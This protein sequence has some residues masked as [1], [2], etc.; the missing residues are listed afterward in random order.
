MQER[1]VID[2]VYEE[3]ASSTVLSITTRQEPTEVTKDCR[4]WSEM[5]YT[6]V[7][8]DDDDTLVIKDDSENHNHRL[9]SWIK[10]T[11]PQK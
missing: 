1:P 5:E 10:V 9:T 2:T 11:K 3:Q 8:D 7:R 6:T 4:S